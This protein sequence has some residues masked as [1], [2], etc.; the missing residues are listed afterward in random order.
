VI[1]NGSFSG[2]AK[3]GIYRYEQPPLTKQK[4][5]LKGKGAV[6][7]N[8][9]PTRRLGLYPCGAVVHQPRKDR[10]Y[11][12]SHTR[13]QTP[14]L[15]MLV[16]RETQIMSFKKEKYHIVRLDLEGTEAASA[17]ISDREKAEELKDA[18]QASK[19][20]CVSVNRE[21]KGVAPPKLFDLTTLQREANKL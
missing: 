12:Q 3:R 14:T 6:V 7:A 13:V 2:G 15:K 4:L 16:D 18:C 9:L 19:A 17:R 11:P 5:D 20:V 21:K 10:R 1:H 8:A